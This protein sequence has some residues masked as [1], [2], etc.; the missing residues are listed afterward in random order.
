M[1][2][3]PYPAQHIQP[4]NIILLRIAAGEIP[5]LNERVQPPEK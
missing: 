2:I 5:A 1:F 4:V 3:N